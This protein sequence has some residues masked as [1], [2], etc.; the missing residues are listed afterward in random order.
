MNNHGNHD[1]DFT[2]IGD[3]T[4]MINKIIDKKFKQHSILIFVQIDQKI[5]FKY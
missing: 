5:Y 4:N 2:Y 3:V 1:R